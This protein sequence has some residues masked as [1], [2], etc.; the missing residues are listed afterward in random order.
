[1]TSIF[2]NHHLGSFHHRSNGVA[3]F[4]FEFIGAAARDR[5]LDQIVSDS[6]RDEGHHV[7]QLNLFDYSAQFVSG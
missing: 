5:A 4:E 6:N 7:A 2:L 3:L 1:M